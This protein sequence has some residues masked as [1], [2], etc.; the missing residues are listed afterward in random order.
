M[1]QIIKTVFYFGPLI[2][3]LGFLTPLFAQIITK[4]G[5]P[6]PFDLSPLMSGLVFAL[7]LGGLAQLR[8]RWI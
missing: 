2:F 8:G 6:T 3:A 7:V 4:T 1:V 5:L